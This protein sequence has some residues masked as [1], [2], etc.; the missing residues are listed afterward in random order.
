MNS[1][2][3]Y[4]TEKMP[5]DWSMT[6]LSVTAIKSGFLMRRLILAASHAYALNIELIFGLLNTVRN[7]IFEKIVLIQISWCL[8]NQNSSIHHMNRI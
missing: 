1:K 5:S 8:K 2:D 7:T 3:T 4:Q 6:L